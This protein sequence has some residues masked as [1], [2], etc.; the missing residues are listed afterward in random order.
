MRKWRNRE[1]V[2]KYCRQNDLITEEAQLKWFDSLPSD[3]TVKMYRIVLENGKDV[4]V[5]GLTSID[6][7]NR[8]AEV[9]LYTVPYDY[10]IEKA[11]LLTLIRHAFST[12]GLQS[13]YLE[14]FK[15]EDRRQLYVDCGFNPEGTRRQFYFREGKFQDAYLY[16]LLAT[17][18]GLRLCS[19]LESA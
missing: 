11:A 9:S 17:E 5:C 16:S 14:S 8:R 4:G 10:G 18:G 15:P 19:H 3:P 13:L 6:L 2:R 12:L 7:W 1:D